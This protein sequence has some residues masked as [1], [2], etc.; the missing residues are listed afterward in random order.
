MN[1]KYSMILMKLANSV[2]LSKFSCVQKRLVL[3]RRVI[4][5]IYNLSLIDHNTDFRTASKRNVMIIT[6]VDTVPGQQIVEYFGLVSGSANRIEAS[7]Y[8]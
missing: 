8:P 6:N 3:L 5:R 4:C 2:L 1:L 7:K